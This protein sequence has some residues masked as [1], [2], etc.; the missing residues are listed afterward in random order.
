MGKA[1]GSTNRKELGALA[2]S[3]ITRRGINFVGGVTGLGLNVTQTG[4]RSWILRYRVS[5][6]RKDMGLGGYPDVTLAQAKELA[7][8]ARIKLA[9]GI[10][11]IAERR[12]ERRKLIAEVAAAVTFKEAAR[13]YIDSQESTWQN[14]KHAQQWRNTIE[15]Y[16]APKLGQLPVKDINL[17]DVLSVLEPIW[18]T[19]TETASRL[20]GRIESIIDWAIAKEYRV[21]SNPA[22]WKGLL[23]KILPAPGKIAKVDHHR[24]LPYSELPAFML[25]LA[26]QHGMGARALEFAILTA[27]R[28]GEVRGATWEEFDLES[29][30]WTVPAS[31][32]KAKKEHRVPLSPKALQIITDLEKTAFCEF[33]FPSSHQP[34]SGSAK[35]SPLSDMTLAAVLRRMEVPAVPHGFRSTFRDWCAEQTDYSNEVAEMALAHT[36]SNKVEAAYRRGD[37]FDKRRQLMQDWESYAFGNRA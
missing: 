3:R 37:L 6:V 35:G 36:I 30:I 31:R 13:R 14:D 24:A 29:G 25:Q 23:D 12:V 34:K 2:V 33:V 28:S 5:G 7:R 15:T 32:M 9:Q 27:C 20:R 21:E 10:D 11:P 4:S 1:M 18:H 19:K 17:A 8:I 16:V 26:K 22:R